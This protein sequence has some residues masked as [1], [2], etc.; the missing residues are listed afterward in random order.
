MTASV[1]MMMMVGK[2]RKRRQQGKEIESQRRSW[3]GL[4]TLR[5]V[6][7][8]DEMVLVGGY[9]LVNIIHITNT[10]PV[11][12]LQLKRTDR[13]DVCQSKFTLEGRGQ[14]SLG[15]FAGL[16]P[17]KSTSVYIGPFVSRA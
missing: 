3:T 12:S 5:N 4:T 2:E 14:P 7:T 10:K 8:Q 13:A 6:N 17:R 15:S 16:F 9:L 1:M 11:P